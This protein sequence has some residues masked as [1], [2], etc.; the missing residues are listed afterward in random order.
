MNSEIDGKVATI[1]ERLFSEGFKKGD[2]VHA[3]RTPFAAEFSIDEVTGDLMVCPVTPAG[4]EEIDDIYQ[5]V[6]SLSGDLTKVNAPC[7][8]EAASA[9]KLPEEI[10]HPR[11][12]CKGGMECHDAIAAA[13]SNL[14]GV[15]A[16]DTGNVI[17]YMWRWADKGGVLDLQKA[18]KYIDYIIKDVETNGIR[19]REE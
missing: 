16:F 4:P 15:Q 3:V 10:D 2:V 19:G 7:V 12:Y 18:R 8:D 17:R 11:R 1:K 6:I 5:I 14:T 13:T 9:P